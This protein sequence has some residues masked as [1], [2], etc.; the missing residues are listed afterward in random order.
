M[1]A[2]LPVDADE[3][4]ILFSLYIK[5]YSRTSNKEKNVEVSKL[6][7]VIKLLKSKKVINIII[8]LAV[9]AAVWCVSI[10]RARYVFV[11]IRPYKKDLKSIEIDCSKT[12]SMTLLK[13]VNRFKKLERLRID[14]YE[15]GDLKHY[16]LQNKKLKQLET[17]RSDVGDVSFL[18]SMSDLECVDFY[19][20]IILTFAL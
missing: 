17:Y 19:R 8:T 2:E 4:E 6:S 12:F 13:N 18:N 14:Y 7:K 11:G 20:I 1:T 10:L 5:H 16:I 15:G 9:I 3:N